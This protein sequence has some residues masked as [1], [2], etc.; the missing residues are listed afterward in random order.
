MPKT[1][2][3]WPHT[4]SNLTPTVLSDAGFFSTQVRHFFL[5]THR[6]AKIWVH[7]TCFLYYYLKLLLFSIHRQGRRIGVLSLC[8]RTTSL[9]RHRQHLFRTWALLSILRLCPICQGTRFHSRLPEIHSHKHQQTQKL[10]LQAAHFCKFYAIK[11]KTKHC[12]ERDSAVCLSSSVSQ[13][14]FLSQKKKHYQ[15]LLLRG[16]N[17]EHVIRLA[18]SQVTDGAGEG[19]TDIHF[20]NHGLRCLSEHMTD[21]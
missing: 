6:C 13:T 17:K 4:S 9:E 18:V 2:V 12:N 21:L 11:I 10:L 14:Y 16:G 20:H 3:N 5:Y 1:F 8:R 7:I 15:D 19:N